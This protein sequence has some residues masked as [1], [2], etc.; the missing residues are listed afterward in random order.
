MSALSVAGPG[1]HEARAEALAP[2]SQTLPS[3]ARSG[4]LRATDTSTQTPTETT[5]TGTTA[6]EAQ[7]IGPGLRDTDASNPWVVVGVSS[8]IVGTIMV[9]GSQAWWDHGLEP[10]HWRDTGYFGRETY[11]GGADKLGHFYA[12]YLLVHGAAS[13][14]GALGVPKTR[15]AWLAG[16]GVFLTANWIE[17]IDGFTEYGFESGDVVANSLGTAL[18]VLTTLSPEVDAVVG[19]RIGYAPTRDFLAHDKTVLKWINDYSG[20][21]F[22]LD[23]KMNGVFS[24][25]DRDPGFWRYVLLGP[26]YGTRDYSPIRR[27]ATRQRI[28]GFQV[29]LSLPEI[30]RNWGEG[31]R[32]VNGIARVLDFY[33]MPLVSIALMKDLNGRTWFLNFGVSQRF[34][35]G[36]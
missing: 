1:R 20:M 23:L 15:A 7:P 5:S 27:M 28:L 3:I 24:L 26:V 16:C 19:A 4:S 17:L 30:L 31:D 11:A 33:A 21:L 14:Y 35:V 18:G 8:A 12:T 25:L 10:F 13:I 29:G 2:T 6:G 9:W 34:N 36:L 32:A 22:Y